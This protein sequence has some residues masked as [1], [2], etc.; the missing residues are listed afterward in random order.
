MFKYLVKGTNNEGKTVWQA[1]RNNVAEA[2]LITTLRYADLRKFS[3]AEGIDLPNL[4]NIQSLKCKGH[5]GIPGGWIK[6][7]CNEDV[8]DPDGK[9]APKPKQYDISV[10]VNG[11]VTVPVYA[12]SLEEAKKKAKGTL[13]FNAGELEVVDYH[14]VN[15]QCTNNKNEYADF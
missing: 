12:I 1:F 15:I 7:L 5:Y 4:A 8:P 6:K 2:P 10:A 11:R 14:P 3:K 13:T 9:I